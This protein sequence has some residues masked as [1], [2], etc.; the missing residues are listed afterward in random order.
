[1]PQKAAR[2]RIG[3]IVANGCLLSA[4]G[5]GAIPGCRYGPTAI[6][7]LAST[8]QASAAMH[9]YVHKCSLLTLVEPAGQTVLAFHVPISLICAAELQNIG[10][11]EET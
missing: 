2:K 7:R 1:M 11:T 5:A 6:A 8:S 3:R 4:H 10:D 9:L